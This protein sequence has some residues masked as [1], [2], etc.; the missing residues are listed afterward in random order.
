VKRKSA[1]K[2]VRPAYTI[3]EALTEKEREALKMSQWTLRTDDGRKAIIIHRHDEKDRDRY[4]GGAWY[5]VTTGTRDSLDVLVHDRDF[6][7]A[8]TAALDLIGGAK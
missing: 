2:P 3:T 6:A 4:T 7:S 5:V 8:I 1:P